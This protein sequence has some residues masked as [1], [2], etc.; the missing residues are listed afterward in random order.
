MGSEMCIRDRKAAAEKAA[1]EKAATVAAAKAAGPSHE[2]L[3]E[4]FIKRKGADKVLNQD[5]PPGPGMMR[6]GE[7]VYV[8][9]GRCGD[10]RIRE[11]TGGNMQ[12]NTP[13]S[14]RCISLVD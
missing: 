5:P 13:R 7:V 10:G 4:R 11:V 12:R 1:A 9:N 2:E 14:F 3:L 6:P 8:N